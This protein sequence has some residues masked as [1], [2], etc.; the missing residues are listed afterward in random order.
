MLKVLQIKALSDNYIYMLYNEDS[1]EALAVD[2]AVSESV[3][4]E[5]LKR[6]LNLN[7]I[8]NTHHHF[9]HVGGNKSLKEKTGCKVIGYKGDSD[10]IP[11]IDIPVEDNQILNI[12]GSEVK[13]LFIPG[14]TKGHIAYLFL[15]EKYLFCGDTLFSMGCGRLF[16]GTPEEMLNSLKL[17]SALPEDTRVYC[18]HEYTLNNAK[19]AISVDPYNEKLRSRF[20]EV[21]KL[22]KNSEPTIP[23]SIGTEIETNPFLRVD[24]ISLRENINMINASE[25]EV[26]KYL[27][28]KK[29]MF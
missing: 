6:N 12:L 27:R 21:E 25:A 4:F 18:A 13:I 5:I 24:N 23:S 1:G 8:L 19:F 17:I 2:P 16:E 11:F 22:R 15:K 7:Y 9:D 20:K 29:D 3:L 28:E 14:H 10:R 26:F